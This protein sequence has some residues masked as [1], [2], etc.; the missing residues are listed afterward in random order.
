MKIIALSL[1]TLIAAA[2]SN[3]PQDPGAKNKMPAK[4]PPLQESAEV[5]FQAFLGVLRAAAKAH[6]VTTLTSMMTENFGYRLDE[7]GS[8]ARAFEHWNENNLW[9]ELSAIL[10]EKF[11]KKDEFMVAPP[12]FA[13]QA[14]SYFGYRAGITRVNG[15]WKFAYFVNGE[16]DAATEQNESG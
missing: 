13:D 1:L 12:E 11:V 6:D 4:R 2:S 14:V 9:P 10:K 8:S 16:A 5:D 3:C 15:S 7:Q